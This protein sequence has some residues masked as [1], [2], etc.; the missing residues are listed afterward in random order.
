M[1]YSWYKANTTVKWIDTDTEENFKKKPN[2]RY[3]TVKVEYVF[4]DYGF[5]TKN[6]EEFRDK[7]VN[8]ALGC[9]FTAGVGLAESEAWPSLIEQESDIPMLNLGIGGGATD[10]VARILTNVAPLFDIQNVYILWP[11]AAR[12]EFYHSHNILTK[13]P[14]GCDIEHIWNLDEPN[15]NQRLFKNYAIVRALSKLHGFKLKEFNVHDVRKIIET[16]SLTQLA[17][18]NAHWGHKVHQV[19]ATIIGDK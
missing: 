6:L 8:I 16:M 10:S 3:E 4:N 15:S 7:K 11:E 18:D 2:P 19:L 13:I 17:R 1:P 5:R 12:F 9:S 14:T